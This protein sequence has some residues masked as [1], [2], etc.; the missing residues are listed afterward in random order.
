MRKLPKAAALLI[1]ATFLSLCLQGTALA[2][3]PAAAVGF[4]KW[5]PFLGPFHS[6]LLHFPIGFVVMAFFVDL[7]AL[8]RRS[9]ET[10]RIIGFILVFAVLTSAMTIFLGLMRSDT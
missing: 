5:Q 10:Q 4:F 7:Y 3:A 9:A 8:C 6:V 2:A 1:A